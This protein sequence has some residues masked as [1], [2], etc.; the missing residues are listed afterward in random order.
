[1]TELSQLIGIHAVQAALDYDDAHLTE[2]VYEKKSTNSRIQ[3][4]LKIAQEKGISCIPKSRQQL[5]KLAKSVRHQ[6]IIAD[7]QA[8]TLLSESELSQA[9]E[10]QSVDSSGRPPLWLV[11]DGITDPGNFG[12]C[13]RTADAVGVSGVVIP[14]NR[15]VGMTPTVRRAACGAADQLAIYQVTNLV[16][17]LK[18]MKDAG[19]W[20]A[21]AAGEAEQSLYDIDFT[22]PMV[23]LLGSEGE[24][25]R[26]LTRENCD[27]LYSIPMHGSVG[28]LNV[29]VANA[30]SLYEV[31]RQRR[32]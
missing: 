16:R 23:V 22:G 19:L 11:F 32:N 12:A 24:G 14:K 21:G 4:I 8:A 28:S 27:Y 29:S 26:H 3:A 10:D 31:L 18:K 6:G 5:D 9:L 15:A 2:L 30:V 20:I 25:L 17:S 7:Y 13:L 1:M